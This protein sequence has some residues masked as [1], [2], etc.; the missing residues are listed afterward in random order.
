MQGEHLAQS[1]LSTNCGGYY[2]RSFQ[3]LLAGGLRFM[4]CALLLRGVGHISLISATLALAL[5]AV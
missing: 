1:K 5:A 4:A 2:D 3:N